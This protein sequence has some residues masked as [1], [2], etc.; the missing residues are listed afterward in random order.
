MSTDK[1][2]IEGIKA[3]IKEAESFADQQLLPL[4]VIG[5][6]ALKAIRRIVKEE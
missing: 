5:I 4:G 1:E 3:I 6:S 2:K